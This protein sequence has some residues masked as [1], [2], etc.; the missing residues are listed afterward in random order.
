[1]KKKLPKFQSMDI[2]KYFNVIEFLRPLINNDGYDVFYTLSIYEI[3][4]SIRAQIFY[5]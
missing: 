2:A 3:D 1:M 5:N 4:T